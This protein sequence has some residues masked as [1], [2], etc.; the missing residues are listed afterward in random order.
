MG[1]KESTIEKI[2]TKDITDKLI[3]LE[4]YRALHF[5]LEYEDFY[6]SCRSFN[7]YLL[8]IIRCQ[9]IRSI[10]KNIVDRKFNNKCY[11]P[12]DK[13]ILIQTINKI[14]NPL[15]YAIEI[16]LFNATEEKDKKI[17]KQIKEA[18][19][20][21]FP[22]IKLQM[23]NYNKEYTI[24]EIF[25]KDITDKLITLED[26]RALYF[27]LEY[28]NYYDSYILF[29]EYFIIRCQD[30]RSIKKNIVDRK[31]NCYKP[32]DKNILIQTIDKIN[33]SLK[34]AIEIILF[35]A[36][37]EKDEDDD[38]NE[39]DDEEDE[40]VKCSEKDDEDDEKDDEEN[41]IIE[42]KKKNEA[43]IDTV[44]ELEKNNKYLGEK[45]D[46][47]EKKCNVLEVENAKLIKNKEYD[48]KLITKYYI[49]K[50]EN[51]ALQTKCDSSLEVENAK[52]RERVKILDESNF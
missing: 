7:K 48:K 37:E 11:N 34:Y 21:L 19:D 41:T 6:Y 33:K 49:L 2:F 8:N 47:L 50:D 10:K 36:T 27:L 14:N 12:L 3:T 23:E 43:L 13:N 42:L 31:F 16:I 15:K 40:E 35:N 28:E 45:N 9:D 20:S 52:L 22:I 30:I 18:E 46:A 44:I 4:D 39:E 5:L 32:L 38:G 29:N 25:T 51:K 24:E 17:K 26:Y 1:N